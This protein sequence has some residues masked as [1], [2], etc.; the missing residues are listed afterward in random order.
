[1]RR[2]LTVTVV[3]EIE[4]V[5]DPSEDVVHNHLE[6]LADG[7]RHAA[8]SVGTRVTAE[9]RVAFCGG[10]VVTSARTPDR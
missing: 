3:T 10:G 8:A 1:M 2:T 5:G 9:V 7:L 4:F 6:R